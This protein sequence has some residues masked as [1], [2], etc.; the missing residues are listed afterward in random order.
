[1]AGYGKLQVVEELLDDEE[2]INK[3]IKL[4]ENAEEN[5]FKYKIFYIKIPDSTPLELR[6]LEAVS[7]YV[8][9]HILQDE[10]TED[11]NLIEEPSRVLTVNS[12]KGRGDDK[13]KY[14]TEL[15]GK[16]VKEDTVPTDLRGSA[17]SWRTKEYRTSDASATACLPSARP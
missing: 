8:D 3:A 17:G 11:I 15:P 2:L 16:S 4:I 7:K 14:L 13:E 6:F 12:L 9:V 1:M 5:K 10:I